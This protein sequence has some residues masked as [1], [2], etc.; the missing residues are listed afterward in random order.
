[1]RGREGFRPPLGNIMLG[2]PMQCGWRQMKAAPGG[3]EL[4]DLTAKKI[5]TVIRDGER[6]NVVDDVIAEAQLTIRLDGREWARLLCTPE[7]ME[8]LALGYLFSR[9]CFTSLDDVAEMRLLGE[10]LAVEVELKGGSAPAAGEAHGG[11]GSGPGWGRAPVFP[12]AFGVRHRQTAAEDALS[13]TAGEIH[14]FMEEMQARASLF[15]ATGG[16]HSAALAG[17]GGILLF[18]E[19]VS[20]H[21][22][23]DKVVGESLQRGIS[24]ENKALL[25]SFRIS[26]EILLKGAGRRL[27]LFISRAA[28]TSLSIEK[29]DALDIT[30]VGFVRGRRMNVYTHP[31]RVKG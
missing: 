15:K 9:G 7:K 23:V 2:P 14:S 24:M 6:L 19:D 28:P 21:N 22:A 29:A 8:S 1:M 18:C 27:P 30:L 3:L 4:S 20:R 16:A 17:K 12:G 10:G 26:L 11:G 13:I 31:Y 25:C 5:I